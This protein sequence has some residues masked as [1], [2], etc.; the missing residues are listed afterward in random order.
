MAEDLQN[1]ELVMLT[2]EDFEEVVVLT[3]H[4]FLKRNPLFIA[5]KETSE[6]YGESSELTIKSALDSGFSLGFREKTKK[7]LV[8][9]NLTL[10]QN[11]NQL[12]K[13]DTYKLTKQS[14]VYR[15]LAMI[16]AD[17]TMFPDVTCCLYLLMVCVHA[18]YCGRGLARMMTQKVLEMG[19]ERGIDAACVQAI[20]TLSAR[21]YTRLG[22]ETVKSLDLSTITD[23]LGLDLSLIPQQET[24]IK[25]MLK[26]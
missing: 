3:K 19:R 8:G 20:N 21:I 22:F 6:S 2:L 9:V 7:K 15:I 5:A 23:E 14:A 11:V 18:D 25:L 13:H 26:R 24:T 12:L 1:I 17:A 10:V 16:D 4:H